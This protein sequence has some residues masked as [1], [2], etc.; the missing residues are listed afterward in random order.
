[1]L[2]YVVR[3]LLLAL[4]MVWGVSFGAF[5]AFGLSFN[6]AYP[7][8]LCTDAACRAQWQQVIDHFHLRDPI[9]QRY[10]LWLSGLV[11]HGFG[12]SVQD[13]RFGEGS[14]PIGPDLWHATWVTAQLLGV[15]L[16]LV[17]VLSVLVGVVSAR[18]AGS[19]L[20]WTLRLLAYV[21]W[22]I[23]T[24]LVGVLLF[25]WLAPHAWFNAAH[26]DHGFLGW[27]RWMTLPAITLA[28]GLVGLYSRY[29]RSAMLTALRQPY[30]TVARGK[31]L[32]ERRVT[33]R[34]ALRNSLI[35]FV[36]VLTLDLAAI[37]GASLATDYVFGLGG[38]A[39]FFL[40]SVGQA[41][42]FV[43][44]AVLV[45][46]AAVVA[47]FMLL[48]DLAVGWLDPRAQVVRQAG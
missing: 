33:L 18:L 4:S 30:A 42:P 34:H 41:D 7:Y 13:P 38:L 47:V 29:V 24:F 46:I 25:R 20:D 23:P 2:A 32:S 14:R 26:V 21:A 22:S 5:V 45:V 37:V 6:P 44:T 35:P 16:L 43:M 40:H 36:S 10:W 31:G 11:G 19:P 39:A 17:V 15:S 1:M 3:R 12:A 9:L 28:L 48:S 27:L 8:N